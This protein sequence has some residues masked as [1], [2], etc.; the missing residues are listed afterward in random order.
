MHTMLV[1]PACPPTCQCPPVLLATPRPSAPGPRAPCPALLPCSQQPAT[2]T[3]D[4]LLCL[5]A[6][7]PCSLQPVTITF[8]FVLASTLYI[9]ALLSIQYYMKSWSH[10]KLLWFVNI[11]N[12]VLAFTYMKALFNTTLARLGFK[13][14]IFKATRKTKTALAEESEGAGALKSKLLMQAGSQQD[15]WSDRWVMI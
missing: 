13:V 9:T 8:D 4:T 1:L 12:T 6:F 15:L 3:P 5:P 11:S 7:L 2:L 10:A 14:T